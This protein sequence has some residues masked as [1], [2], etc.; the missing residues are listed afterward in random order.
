MSLNTRLEGIQGTIESLCQSMPL[1][2]HV[3]VNLEL[4][5]AVAL[6]QEASRSPSTWRPT[7]RRI[8]HRLLRPLGHNY[9]VH[10]AEYVITEPLESPRMLLNHPSGSYMNQPPI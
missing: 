7:L 5:N 3:Q 8:A 1:S 10:K 6:T 4:K 9:G 2:S